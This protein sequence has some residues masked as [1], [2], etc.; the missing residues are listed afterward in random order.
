M[1]DE[2]ENLAEA[3]KPALITVFDPGP[4]VMTPEEAEKLFDTDETGRRDAERDEALS[5][6]RE[7]SDWAD[8]AYRDVARPD[9]AEVIADALAFVERTSP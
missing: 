9:G 7:L 2:R 5:L 3:E 4:Y 1:S 8:L 6:L